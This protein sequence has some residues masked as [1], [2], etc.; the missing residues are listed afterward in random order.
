MRVTQ[1]FDTMPCSMLKFKLFRCKIPLRFKFQG[2]YEAMRQIPK[3][4]LFDFQWI[5][6]RYIPEDENLRTNV[7]YL[8]KTRR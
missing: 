4:H 1:F 5:T 2:I 8:K 7:I 3:K 6:P